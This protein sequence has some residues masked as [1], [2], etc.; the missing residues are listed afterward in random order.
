MRGFEKIFTSLWFR[1]LMGGIRECQTSDLKKSS[2]GNFVWFS[3]PSCVVLGF[4]GF[5]CVRLFLLVFFL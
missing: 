3:G 1:A 2:S 4:V 5:N